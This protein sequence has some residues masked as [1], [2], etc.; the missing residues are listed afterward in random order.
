MLQVFNY[1]NADITFRTESGVTYL[2]APEMAK[3]FGKFPADWLRLKGTDEYVKA[4]SSVKG[5]P[6]TQLIVIHQGGA[7]QGTWLHEDIAIEFARWLSP[8][9]SI[10]CND[11]I[12]E[13]LTVGVTR[14]PQL[15]RRQLLE[16]CLEAETKL[17]EQ[18]PKI[19]YH[20]RVLNTGN[21]FPIGVIAAELGMTAN[22]LNKIL[23]ERHVQHKVGGTW[24]LNTKYVDKGYTQVNTHISA[25]SEGEKA[26][27]HTVWT[28]KGR[29][30]I[31]SIIKPA[32]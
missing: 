30:F 13:L 12:K 21:G 23:S 31:H 29:Q 15:S 17:E 20:D 19:A 28:E 22:K 1:N 8:E 2:N 7:D 6:I 18:A 9:F 16:M 3:P 14:L 32:A 4:Y 24:I 25:T 26:H 5:I 27:H 11:R 10:W